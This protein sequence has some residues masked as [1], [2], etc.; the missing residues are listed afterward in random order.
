MN[1]LLNMLEGIIPEQRAAARRL[2][3]GSLA[4]PPEPSQLHFYFSAPPQLHVCAVYCTVIS[5]WL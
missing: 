1:Y 3:A 2:F 4:L 5:L